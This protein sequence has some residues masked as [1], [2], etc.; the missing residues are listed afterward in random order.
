M[1][2]SLC[3]PTNGVMEWICPVIES[4]YGQDVHENEFEVIVVDNGT[5]KEFQL[6]MEECV[7][8][9]TNLIYKRIKCPIFMNE[10][11]AYKLAGGDFIKFINHRTLLLDGTLRCWI[12]FMNENA[13]KKPV[14]Y[15]SNGVLNK[16]NTKFFFTTFNQFLC[17]L[18]FWSSWSTG[19]AIWKED[20][21]RIPEN[22]EYNE[23]FPHTTILFR[24]Y[25]NKKTYIIDNNIYLHEL[26]HNAVQKGSYDLFY[27]FA[28][29]ANPKAVLNLS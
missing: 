3:I 15:F 7:S 2:I 26:P 29:D 1:K 21:E 16:E 18:S 10:I 5:N 19:M 27:A 20:L 13:Q 23:L 14:I 28:V 4:I 12:D 22:E 8:R 24:N 6:Y 25:N 11:Y 9:H 17:N